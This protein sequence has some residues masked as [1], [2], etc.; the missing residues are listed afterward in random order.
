MDMYK[1]HNIRL[2]EYDRFIKDIHLERVNF[3]ET[4]KTSPSKK[5]PSSIK[6]LI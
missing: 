4:L 6:T 2:I 5:N 1:N 3:N